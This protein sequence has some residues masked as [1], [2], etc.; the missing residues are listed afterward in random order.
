MEKGNQRPPRDT[1]V[2]LRYPRVI[3][4]LNHTLDDKIM[5][6]SLKHFASA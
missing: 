1:A 6:F 3:S 4:Y 2:N 5:H